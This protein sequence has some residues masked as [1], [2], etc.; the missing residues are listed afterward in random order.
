MATFQVVIIHDELFLPE[1]DD[2]FI[3]F[4]HWFIEKVISAICRTFIT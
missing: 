1:N 4:Y 3:I 2:E